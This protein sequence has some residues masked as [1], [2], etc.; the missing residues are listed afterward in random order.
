[1]D[2]TISE[3]AS[4]LERLKEV[5]DREAISDLIHRFGVVL[6]DQ[7]F[8][9]LQSVFAEDATIT[10]P[11]GRAQ[12]LDAIVAQATRNHTPELRT[13]HLVTDLVVDLDGERARA[14][15]NYLAVFFTG[16]GDPAPSPRFQI[17]SVYRFELVRTT[18][19]WRLHTM[20]MLP[21]WAVG[22]RP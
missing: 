1:M 10:T 21:T 9:D 13:Q 19:G 2:T 11:G 16:S 17:G 8:D 3:T 5:L 6:D 12:G 18:G 7:R 15:A 4:E 20:E 22:E 14:R